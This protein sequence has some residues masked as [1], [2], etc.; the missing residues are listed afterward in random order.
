[1]T[2]ILNIGSPESDI[3]VSKFSASRAALPTSLRRMILFPVDFMM[4]SLNSS[5]EA[6]F[7]IVFT[8]N[9]VLEPVNFPEGSST[10]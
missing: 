9:S 6:K 10:F 7:P 1:M 5:S 2:A 8:V 4:I 3:F